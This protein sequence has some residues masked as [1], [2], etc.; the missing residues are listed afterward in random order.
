MKK[1]GEIILGLWCAFASFIS[2][3]WLTMIFLDLTGEIYKYDYSI[4]E[5]VAGIIGA[6]EL[7]VWGLAV[8]FPDIAF[9]KKMYSRNRKYFFCALVFFTALAVICTAMCGWNVVRFLTIPGGMKFGF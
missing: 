9:L 8:L 6:A 3:I 2:P 4:D 1:I 7:V 5:G